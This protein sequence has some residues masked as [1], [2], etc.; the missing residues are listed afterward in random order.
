MSQKDMRRS[1]WH[2]LLEKEY[3]SKDFSV[4]GI[5]G[6]ASLLQIRKVSAPLII[7]NIAGHVLIADSGIS[8]LQLALEESFIWI[9][10]MYDQNDAFIQ[11]YFD[12][13]DGNC[14]ANPDNPTFEDMYLDVV[15]N[16]DLKLYLL[17]EEE[18]EEALLNR[19]ISKQQYEDATYHCGKLA[20]YLQQN[21][22]DFLQYCEAVYSELKQMIP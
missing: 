22:A 8:W 7:D 16:K 2:R 6:K 14:F 5:R 17:D 4:E 15:L 3:V 9:T 11:A 18:L 12:I 13:T 21:A 20:C 19:H 1:D 10:V